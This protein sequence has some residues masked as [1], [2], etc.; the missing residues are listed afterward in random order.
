MV[1]GPDH[2]TLRGQACSDG[3]PRPGRADGERDA[4]RVFADLDYQYAQFKPLLDHYAL[5][6]ADDPARERLRDALIMSYLPLARHMAQRYAHRGVPVDDLVQVATIGLINAIDRYQPHHPRGFLVYAVPT[7]RGE[8]RRYFRDHTWSMRVSR[9]VKD[10]CVTLNATSAELSRVLGR[11]PRP[12]E[13]AAWLRVPVEEVLE[14]LRAS[15]ETHHIPSL[16]A[17]Q[18]AASDD[19]ATLGDLLGGADARLEM[20]EYRHALRPLLEEL[21]PRE[22][23]ILVLRF[24]GN[25]TQAEIGERLGISQMHVCRL[26]HATLERLRQQLQAASSTTN[27]PQ[28]ERC[29]SSTESCGTSRRPRAH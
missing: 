13:L 5:L 3:P 21:P 26:L 10:L 12:T 29:G 6:A 14:A 24:F 1:A 20:V 23:T 18:R 9:R 27:V 19:Q 8:I 4:E 7:M 2:V 25:M 11:A 22:R 17:A 16:D 15:E 28:Q